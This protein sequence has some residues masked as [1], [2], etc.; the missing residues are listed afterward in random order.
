M[1]PSSTT[2]RGALRPLRVRTVR[3]QNHHFR[4]GID[5][6]QRNATFVARTM[7]LRRLV[8]WAQAFA[9]VPE[10]GYDLVHSVNA[11][12]IL[13]GRPYV[14]SFESFLPRVPED[15][16]IGWLERS[17]QRRLLRDVRSGRCLALLAMSRFAIRQFRAQNRGFAGREELEGPMRVLYPAIET[18]HHAPKPHSAGISLLFVGFNFIGKGGP[19]LLRAHEQL[20]ARGLPVSTTVVSSLEWAEDDFLGPPSRAYV[21][22]ELRRLGGEGITHHRTLPN[23]ETLEL[24]RAVDYLVLP[25]LHDT[26]GYVAI[27]ALSRGTA[28]IA[29]DTCA[30]PEIVE[31][32]RCGF[33]LPFER[34]DEVGRWRYLYQ[35][36]EA[37]YLDHFEEA[38]ELLTQG[39][40][41]AVEHSWEKRRDYEA[42][43]QGAL[44]RART[45]FSRD[46][47]R[48]MLEQIYERAR[49]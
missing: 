1:P 5:V 2:E 37:D 23:P 41:D 49:P 22:R 36:G 35:T 25:T 15:T 12:P 45:R 42:L 26:F 3:R 38:I 44:D 8:G 14:I 34:D 16:Y 9:P 48:A 21:E 27:E 39:I 32:G 20:R 47:A 31:H 46:Y 43:S 11:V 6:G 10:P 30:L 29:T 19:A 17:L 28:V 13:T 18:P 40:V 4:L 33:L 24:M 7:T